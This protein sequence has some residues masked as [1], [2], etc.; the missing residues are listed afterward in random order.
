MYKIRNFL[1]KSWDTV[2]IPLSDK[3][4]TKILIGGIL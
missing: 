1:H 4:S 2:K 3:E